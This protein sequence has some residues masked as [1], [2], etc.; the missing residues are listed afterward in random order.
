MEPKY[1]IAN[2]KG[3]VFKKEDGSTWVFDSKEKALDSAA[4]YELEDVMICEVVGHFCSQ[5]QDVCNSINL[6]F[7]SRFTT[8]SAVVSFVAQ[9]LEECADEEWNDDD[10]KMA[11]RRYLSWV[12]ESVI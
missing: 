6:L 12:E 2:K 4:I 1:I 3:E 11:I 8:N 7:N 9:D 10:L 5:K